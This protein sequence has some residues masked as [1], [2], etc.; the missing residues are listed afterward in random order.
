MGGG[1]DRGGEYA[2]AL[3]AYPLL[4]AGI[5][6][7]DNAAELF[8]WGQG[9]TPCPCPLAAPIALDWLSHFAP[10]SAASFAV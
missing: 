6:I 3:F 7:D 9:R 5:D 1:K 10:A 2:A 8:T 4:D